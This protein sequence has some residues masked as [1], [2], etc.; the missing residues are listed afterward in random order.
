MT[1][2]TRPAMTL[3]VCG[4]LASSK[5]SAPFP[6]TLENPSGFPQTHSHD[7]EISPLTL[8]RGTDKD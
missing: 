1:H 6:Q 5:L 7:D 8:Y 3:T 2:P 4:K